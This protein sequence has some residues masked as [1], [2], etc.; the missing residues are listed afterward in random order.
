MPRP[1]QFACRIALASVIGFAALATATP[2]AAAAAAASTVRA[3]AVDYQPPVD[4][5]IADGFRP[6]AHPYGAGNRGV[7]YRTSSGTKVVA[8]ADGVV[9]FAGQVGFGRHVVV[10]HA[11]GV[12][13]SY[14]FL[15]EVEVARGQHL[16]AGDHVGRAGG[17][18]HVGA[19]VGDTY[20]D[21]LGLFSGTETHAYLVDDD[22]Q[23]TR[24]AP[25]PPA[26]ERS[27]LLDFV[28]GLQPE[29]DAHEQELWRADQTGCTPAEVAVPAAPGTNRIAVL[30]GGL[31][32]ATGGAAILGLDTT[33]LGYADADT[34][35]F[36]YRSDGGAYG[37]ADTQR[38]LSE[39]ASLLAAHIA[40]LHAARPDAAI[41]VF[42]HSQGG[43]VARA[44]A[45]T[46][47][48]AGVETIVTFGT[49]HAGN[50]LAA[51]AQELDAASKA[52]ATVFDL[53][54]RLGIGGIDPTST[55]VAQLG[56]G[57]AFIR[58][59]D[60]DPRSGAE[61]VSVAAATDAVVPVQAS[62]WPAA[63]NVTVDLAGPPT[64]LDHGRLPADGAATREAALAVAGMG[65]TCDT[66]TDWRRKRLLGATADA[67]Q[68][69]AASALASVVRWVDRRLPAGGMQVVRL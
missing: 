66:L 68:Q 23:H 11:D 19:R 46:D 22:P 62:R 8:A 6:P 16:R 59:L 45:A 12:R 7:E 14:S 3:G 5:P 55:S 44:A 51:A 42:A 38:D 26:A 24:R 67:V 37:P 53:A 27:A 29:P 36:S 34:T 21:P 4:A 33:A 69:G 30:V 18:L 61:L 64:P 57:S 43:L 39:A 65:V 35:Q 60:G 10:L 25:L 58:S 52:A 28:R 48:L 13:T 47:E 50:A 32:S 1:L 17:R 2:R 9:T 15:A 20:I 49:P 31:G 54:V 40:K 56:A 41:D 63:A